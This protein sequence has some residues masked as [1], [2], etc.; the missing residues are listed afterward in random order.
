MREINFINGLSQYQWLIMSVGIEH[1]KTGELSGNVVSI[2]DKNDYIKMSRNK[3]VISVH[4][5]QN[6]PCHCI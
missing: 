3:V 5:T 1:S 6:L 2:F 4:Q